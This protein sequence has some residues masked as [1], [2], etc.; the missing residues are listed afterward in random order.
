MNAQKR[1]AMVKLPHMKLWDRES[2]IRWDDYISLRFR[3]VDDP[4]EAKPGDIVSVEVDPPWGYPEMLE[5][6]V[7]DWPEREPDMFVGR[8]ISTPKQPLKEFGLENYAG[9]NNLPIPRAAAQ[10]KVTTNPTA[11]VKARLMK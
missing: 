9:G 7:L 4:V 5:F 6:R 11:A 1:W 10:S 2:T 3:L 8:L